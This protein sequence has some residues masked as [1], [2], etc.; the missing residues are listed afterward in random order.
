MAKQLNVS[1]Y[2]DLELSYVPDQQPMPFPFLASGPP[3]C[4]WVTSKR[5]LNLMYVNRLD[6]IS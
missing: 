1:G 4:T 2:V 3:F 6:A 5:S